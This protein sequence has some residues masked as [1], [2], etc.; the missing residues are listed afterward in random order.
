MCGQN[1]VFH[2]KLGGR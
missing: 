1:A 2:S